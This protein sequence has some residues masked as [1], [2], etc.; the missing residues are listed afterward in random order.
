MEWRCFHCGDVFHSERDARLHFGRDERSEAACL[1][2]AGAEG[3]LLEALRR[4]E[5]QADDAIQMM[6]NE[7]TDA[8]KAYHSQRCR[9]TQAL[10]AAEQLGYDS[11][12]K[13][14]REEAASEIA[15][16]REENKILRETI[17][18]TAIVE[19]RKAALATAGGE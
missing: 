17:M 18:V 1:I 11:G 14:G 2:K 19:R 12:L 15:R 8:A 3:S 16:L 6:H 5:G 9:H 13:D 7:S 10:I 4:A